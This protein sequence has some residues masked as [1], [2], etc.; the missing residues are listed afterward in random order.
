MEDVPG[1]C[2]PVAFVVVAIVLGR[3]YMAMK[4]QLEL[5]RRVDWHALIS[6]IQGFVY[7]IGAVITIAL[8][9]DG[10]P[11]DELVS[12]L[13]TLGLNGFFQIIKPPKKRPEI[14]KE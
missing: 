6:T 14:E 5:I 10:V 11:G 13:G 4:V 1:I 9:I 3:A 7:V 2:W 12:V 8:V